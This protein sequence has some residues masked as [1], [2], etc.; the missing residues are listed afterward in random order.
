[1]NNSFHHSR[2][3]AARR[4]ISML[5][6]LNHFGWVA[7]LMLGF[8]SAWAF[9]LGGPVNEAYQV[10]TI[11]YNLPGDI[12]APKNIGEEYRWNTPVNYYAFHPSFLEYFGT[13][14]VNAVEQAIGIINA[15]T[16]TPFSSID[17]NQFPL[18]VYRF[19]PRA[20]ALHLIDLKTEA[21]ETMIEEL[22]LVQPDRYV[23]T[24]RERRVQPGL[25]CPFMIYHVIMRNFDPFTYEPT[26]YINGVLF[27]YIIR[28][29][30]TGPDP[31][32]VTI[33]FPVD[34]T[35]QEFSAVATRGGLRFGSYAVGLSRDDVG[36]LRYLYRTNNVNWESASGNS[37]LFS[38]NTTQAQ[39]LFTSNLTL[40]ASAALTNN[41]A[42]LQALFPDLQ[43]LS[44]TNS[45]TNV[46]LTTV[47]PYFTNYVF[48]PID[49]LPHL[50]F[51]TNRT[52]TIQTLFHHTF[53]N[54][55]TFSNT[56]DGFVAVPLLTLPPATNRVKF[57]LETLTVT[58][59]PWMPVGTFFTNSFIQGF[60][61]NVVGGQ[62]A[63]LPTNACSTA[64]IGVQ[65]VLTNY[66]TNLI[67]SV[68]NTQESTNQAGGG[69]NNP[70]SQITAFTQNLVI[71]SLDPVFIYYPV[72]CLQTNDT[73]LQGMD[74]IRFY[75]SSYDSLIGRF[76][77][78]ITNNYTLVS[79]TNSTIHTNYYQRIISSPD[80]LFR[81]SDLNALILSRTEPRWRT[82]AI[83]GL[84]GP[85]S[86]DPGVDISFNR[87][88]PLIINVYDPAF[89]NFGLSEQESVSQ[90]FL[91]TNFVWGSFNGS[92]D[93]FVIYPS[94]ASISALE[95][96]I[97]FS[98]ISVDL[99]PGNVGVPYSAQLQAAGGQAPYIWA[100]TA[101]S[102]PLPPG[103]TL[104]ADGSISG[105][106]EAEGEFNFTVMVTEAGARSSTRTL[107]L[108]INP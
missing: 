103:L 96:Q 104:S 52:L 11:G 62:Y 64:I 38:T 25:S 13:N 31:L 16:N 101:D 95:D 91:G 67:V 105:T 56:P 12:E 71:R 75:R 69:T 32:G 83:P 93:E 80:V 19:N 1:M 97:L 7:A 70:F 44:T 17:L 94:G 106:P 20:Q 34:E 10:S 28:E 99:P 39:L 9:S 3:A 51:A 23:W 74:T 33:N 65:A 87:V 73:L 30:C 79:I 82:N 6:I 50:V 46:F 14:G 58:N 27:T 45:F 59:A 76:F 57:F 24:L 47:T 22:P 63:I 8:P 107:K 108:I 2:S 42:A 29:I 18:E 40:F 5:R 100:P 60:F 84:A 61:T 54:L 88:G 66:I 89:V 21:L 85:G 4:H 43:I 37:V 49:A 78:P 102:T 55:V 86:I 26:P 15:L 48:D 81:S 36:G 77:Q 53:G 90:P 98:I 41:A 72:E 35:A 92:P 68:T